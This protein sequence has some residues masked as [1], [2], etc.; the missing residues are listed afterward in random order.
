MEM[1]K[2]YFVIFIGILTAWMALGFCAIAPKGAS[3]QTALTPKVE[4]ERVEVASYFPYDAKVRV[5]LI[6]AFVFKLE[7]PN[8]YKMGLE[9]INFTVGFEAQGKPGEFF[10]LATPMVYESQ[11]IP[12]KTTNELRVTTVIDSQVVPGNLAVTSG[13]RLA[14]L[15]LK[16]PDLIQYW[17]EKIGDFPF[18]IRVSEGSASFTGEK[19]DTIVGF[20]GVFPKK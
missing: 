6:L 9:S 14:A 3:G 16:A 10:N 17:Y 13:A 18:A 4:L 15:G 19:G 1:R 2:T 12:P 7:N 20:E 11:Y 8:D 5:P